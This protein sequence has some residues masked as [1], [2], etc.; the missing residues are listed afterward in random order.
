MIQYRNQF[1]SV[2]SLS[3]FLLENKRC[4][5]TCVSTLGGGGGA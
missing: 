5:V 4:F 1:E 2:E 3:I